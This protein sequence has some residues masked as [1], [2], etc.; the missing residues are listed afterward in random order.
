MENA[1]DTTG[2]YGMDNKLED[3]PRLGGWNVTAI[4]SARTK[5]DNVDEPFIEQSDD[6]DCSKFEDEN[7]NR[8]T[9]EHVYPP[10][11]IVE[12]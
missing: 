2:Y 7:Q 4:Y 3:K 11:G 12:Q 10:P 9:V 1:D 6:P 8:V 5:L